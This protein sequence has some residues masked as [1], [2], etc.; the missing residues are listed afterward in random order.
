MLEFRNV[1]VAYGSKVVLRAVNRRF[2]AGVHALTG[3]NGCG[4]TT[5]LSCACGIKAPAQGQ[6]V[7]AGAD[8]YREPVAAKMKLSYMPDKPYV[9]PSMTGRDLLDLVS[10]AKGAA[11]W[12][13]APYIERFKL[14][15]FVA[16]TFGSMSLGTQRKFTFIAALIGDP[17]VLLLDE[18]SNAMDQEAHEQM[19]AIITGFAAERAV[20]LT[21]HNAAL[22]RDLN[23]SVVPLTPEA[24]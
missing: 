10:K 8:L 6:V 17:H 1:S 15:Q 24:Q 9:F 23:A 2:A 4:K 16:A 20:I 11:Q 22:I 21:T 3:P 14:S 5:L 12:N 13:V 7:V 19:S 18:P